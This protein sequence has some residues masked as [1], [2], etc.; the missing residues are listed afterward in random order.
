MPEFD[1]VIRTRRSVRGFRAEPLAPALIAEILELA[2]W[3]PSNCNIQPWQVHVVSGEALRALGRA[4]SEAA[5]R[6]TRPVPDVPM[7]TRY[8]GPFRE[9]QIGAAKALYGAMGIA[10]DDHAGRTAAFLRNLDAFGAPHAAFIFLP[11]GF[12]LREAADLGG[13][14]QTLMLAMAS[15]GVASC[16]QGALSL[17]PDVV[18]THLGLEAGA[19]LIMGI[20]FGHEDPTHPANA[21]RTDRAALDALVRFHG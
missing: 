14:T 20:A 6:G 13:F 7:D 17:Y 15:R 9:R 5:A 19:H 18:R 10:R 8:Q 3:A 4:M 16:A 2:R 11:Q 1:T 12:G 21:A